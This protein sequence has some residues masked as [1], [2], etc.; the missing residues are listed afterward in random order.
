MFNACMAQIKDSVAPDVN[1]Q[2]DVAMSNPDEVNLAEELEEWG[3]C[4]R[5][6]TLLDKLI[7]RY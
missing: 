2:E 1:S 6:K 5:D 7:D 3:E 4:D